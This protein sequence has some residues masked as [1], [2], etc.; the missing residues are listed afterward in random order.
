MDFAQGTVDEEFAK[1][2]LREAAKSVG[3]GD[4]EVKRTVDSAWR[5]G[6]TKAP[7]EATE[8]GVAR[9]F[10]HR[11]GSKFEFDP[12]MGKWCAW[13]PDG[14]LQGADHLV[15][16]ELRGIARETD[17]ASLRSARSIKG[18][19]QLLRIDPSH[20]TS[21][22]WDSNPLILGVPGGVVELQSGEVR[23]AKPDDRVT[24]CTRLAPQPCEPVEWLRFLAGTTGGD[25][26]LVGFLQRMCG[27]ALSGHTREQV[28]FFIYG[29][30]GNGKS[31]FLEVL[32]TCLGDYYTTANMEA[33]T[34]ADEN[35]HPT[36]LARLRGARSV[37]ASET[38]QGSHWDEARLKQLT[39]GDAVTARFMRQDFFTF[40]PQF[41]LVFV[42]NHKP[43]LTNI[44][45]AIRRRLLIIPFVLKPIR[46]DPELANK[47][48]Q[49]AGAILNWAIQ[50]CIQWQRGGL[51]PPLSVRAATD[52]FLA[53]EDHLG[54]WIEEC[55]IRGPQ[56]RSTPTE[57]HDSWQAFSRDEKVPHQSLAALGN[58]LEERGYRRQKSN[59]NRYHVGLRPIQQ[60]QTGTL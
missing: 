33:F 57:L 1:A 43:H 42:G 22:Q 17:K 36:E 60:G 53:A 38:R 31:V 7:V 24:K 16:D 56:E 51:R 13:T 3:L 30:G 21:S 49:E 6:L 26:D 44:D 27:Y 28:F 2:Q 46:P 59:G 20:R 50:G 8:D 32:S 18:A 23:A 4:D 45:D 11:H 39:G 12:N 54:R 5:S 34:S 41:K 25:N 19:E 37:G 52:G 55:C 35:R 15:L 9:A 48:K 58:L 40:V 47:L 14:W 10:T 29:S